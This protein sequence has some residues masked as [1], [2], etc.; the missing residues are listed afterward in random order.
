MNKSIYAGQDFDQNFESRA[1]MAIFGHKVIKHLQIYARD[2]KRDSAWTKSNFKALTNLFP[3]PKVNC[4]HRRSKGS[5]KKKGREFLWDFI[6][7][8]KTEGFLYL[9]A[10]SEAKTCNKE[11]MRKLKHDFEKL[12]YVFAPI[13]VMIC[14]SKDEPHAKK[15][16]N[17]LQ[18]YG[19]KHCVNFSAESIF[20]LHCCLW[21]KRG[22]VSYLWQSNSGQVKATEHELINFGEPIIHL[23]N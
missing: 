10:E 11:E 8:R 7:Q 17:D 9:V 4:F 19:R 6:A 1:A 13:R 20:I 12:L 5:S 14:K 18:A 15:I 3:K 23:N 21:K 16:V 2:F 22:S